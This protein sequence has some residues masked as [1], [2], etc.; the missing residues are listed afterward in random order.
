MLLKTVLLIIAS[1]GYQPIEYGHTRQMLEEANIKVEV[2]SNFKHDAVANPNQPKPCSCNK[3]AHQ[4]QVVPVDFALS[5]VNADKYDGIFIIGGPGALGFLDTKITHEIMQTIAKSG[6]PFGA[7]CISPR[8]L[9]AAGV[10]DGKQATGWDEDNKL[11]GIFKQHN[12]TYVKEPVV[13]DG[14]LVTADGPSAALAFG[15]AIVA[16]MQKLS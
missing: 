2:A 4:Y 14:S 1:Q 15:K 13:T 8:I 5:E 7:L 12:V 11:T 6:K 10:L 3:A 16:V 9:A